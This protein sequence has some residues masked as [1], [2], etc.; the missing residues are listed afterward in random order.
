MQGLL[1]A[2]RVTARVL[3]RAVAPLLRGP[4]ESY[5]KAL[6]RSY[7]IRS[8]AEPVIQDAMGRAREASRLGL[9]GEFA[10]MHV[11]VEEVREKAIEKVIAD[12]AML[13]QVARTNVAVMKGLAAK[14][15]KSSMKKGMAEV[16][17]FNGACATVR[18]C[19]KDRHDITNGGGDG[20]QQTPVFRMELV[21]PV[22]PTKTEKED[23]DR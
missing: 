9:A 13:D 18:G 2:E 16:L 21:A 20:E 4:I 3:R 8:A 6:A 11:G 7:Q 14:M 10:A 23:A 19:V 5:A 17:L 15:R 1:D 12:V 22:K